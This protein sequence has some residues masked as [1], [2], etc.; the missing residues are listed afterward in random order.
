[1]NSSVRRVPISP[2]PRDLLQCRLARKTGK[3]NSKKH[4][5]RK[6]AS[7]IDLPNHYIHR[8]CRKRSS[9]DGGF[10]GVFAALAAGVVA[11]EMSPSDNE[12][13]RISDRGGGWGKIRMQAVEN[14][15]ARCRKEEA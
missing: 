14:K 12:G 7:R 10:G 8:V 3:E 5:E 4:Y 15:N 6:T 1:V 2:K 13:A 9:T 11:T